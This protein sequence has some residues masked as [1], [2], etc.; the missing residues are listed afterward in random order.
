MK[1]FAIYDKLNDSYTRLM[2]APSEA[3]FYRDL[4][5]KTPRDS[6]WRSHPADFSIVHVCDVDDRCV[7]SHERPLVVLSSLLVIFNPLKEN[8]NEA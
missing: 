3:G 1:Y 6:V 4:A 7:V 2:G 5:D 8:E